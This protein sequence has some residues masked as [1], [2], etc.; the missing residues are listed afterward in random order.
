MVVA[1]A[2]YPNLALPHENNRDRCSA[3]CV[4]HTRHVPFVNLHPSSVTGP[5]MIKL[6]DLCWSILAHMQMCRMSLMHVRQ[7]AGIGLGV[8]R[9]FLLT[10]TYESSHDQ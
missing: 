9:V 3:E 7:L 8:K 6:P 4:F 2:F 1:M 10:M 5:W